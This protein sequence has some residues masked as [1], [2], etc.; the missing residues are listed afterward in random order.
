[1]RRDGREPTG[2]AAVL[3]RL[4][5]DRAWDIPAAGGSIL[6]QWPAIAATLSP[7]AGRA[8]PGG[9]LLRGVRA[10]GPAPELAR[11]RHAAAPDQLLDRRRGERRDRHPD[12]PHRPRPGRRRHGPGAA[13]GG[14]RS[15]G[16]GCTRGAGRDARRGLAR[17]LPRAHRPPGRP[18]RSA[19]QLGRHRGDRTAQGYAGAQPARVSRARRRPGRCAGLD[20]RCSP[21]ATSSGSGDRDRRSVPGPAERGAR[22]SG[23]TA[24][25]P[26]SA[27]LRTTASAN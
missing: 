9:R 5:A 27:V 1:M 26:E 14:H 3:Q 15:D 7:E 13:R 19:R 18:A 20:G 10:A 25:V 22:L 4:M 8:R 11:V 6:D 21:P 16:G 2:F 23:T 17:L 24:S 12:G